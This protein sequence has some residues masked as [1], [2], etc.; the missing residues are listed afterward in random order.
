VRAL[1]KIQKISTSLKNNNVYFPEK[2]AEEIIC[3]ILQIDK[4]KLYSHNPE[5][6]KKTL[7]KIDQLVQRRLKREPLQYIL[8]KCDF[9]NITIK[10]GKGVLIPR[11]ETE[12]LVEELLKI[13]KTKSKKEY[14]LL[15]L[16]TG[17]GCIALAIAKNLPY[18]KV[19]G[20]DI[21]EKAIRYAEENK[22]LNKISNASFVVGDLFSSFKKNSFFFI[23][24]NPPYIKTEEI[25]LLQPEI[26]EYEPTI[27]LDGGETGLFYYEKIL[28]EASY[29]LL[30]EGFIFLEIG[31]NQSRLIKEIANK[32]NLEV[33]KTVKDFAEIERVMILKSSKT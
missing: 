13:A 27:S 15:D 5:L 8:G 19:F 12:I 26:K 6:D 11:P 25:P 22:K 4:A 31:F 17:S 30:K 2:E 3:H 18:V 9:F 16:C 29:Y 14:F 32:N 20:V 10:V 21:S 7:Q 28:K 23:T 33:L 1:E 24:A